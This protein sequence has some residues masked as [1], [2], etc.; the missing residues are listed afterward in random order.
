[1]GGGTIRD[2]EDRRREGRG[3]KEKQVLVAGDASRVGKPVAE[4]SE[5]DRLLAK[6]MT[7]L[8]KG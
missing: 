7:Y 2:P 5:K 8:E 3:Q 6:V 1:M 4:G